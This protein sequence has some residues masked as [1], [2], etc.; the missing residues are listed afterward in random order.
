MKLC[1][2]TNGKMQAR[3]LLRLYGC[4]VAINIISGEGQK[5]KVIKQNQNIKSLIVEL[6]LEFANRISYFCLAS[7]IHASSHTPTL[8]VGV[9]FAYST[10]IYNFC[11][12]GKSY[13]PNN[14]GHS[15]SGSNDVLFAT[16]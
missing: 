1:I 8:H 12:S 7:Q 5:S 14:F 3:L 2:F 10:D 13:K 4:C 6:R 9:F 11:T 16:I 15:M